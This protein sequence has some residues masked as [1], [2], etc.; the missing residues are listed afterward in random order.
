MIVYHLTIM[1]RGHLPASDA[2]L[3]IIL[4]CVNMQSSSISQI[5][6]LL[7]LKHFCG[8]GELADVTL[9]GWLKSEAGPAHHNNLLFLIPNRQLKMSC[10]ITCM[11]QKKINCHMFPSPLYFA[12]N[13]ILPLIEKFSQVKN[14]SQLRRW[15]KLNEKTFPR[16]TI[17]ACMCA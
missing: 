14:S 5:G 17:S 11:L 1:C 12:N 6:K 15:R 4:W 7:L 16:W 3:K 10:L 2:N 13:S 8:V 9:G